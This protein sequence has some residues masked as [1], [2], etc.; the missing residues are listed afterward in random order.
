M[1]SH[2]LKLFLRTSLRNAGYTTI[3]VSGLAIG[4]ASSILI[5]LWFGTKLISTSSTYWL[6][7]STS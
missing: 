7:G 5:L 1:I 2:F 3:N 4:L 6:I